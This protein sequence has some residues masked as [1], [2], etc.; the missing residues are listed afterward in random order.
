MK[1]SSSVQAG[2]FIR[3]RVRSASADTFFIATAHA[4]AARGDDDRSHGVDVSHRAE[5]SPAA[6]CNGVTKALWRGGL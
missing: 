6:G 4:D 3:N 1:R 2:I 5:L